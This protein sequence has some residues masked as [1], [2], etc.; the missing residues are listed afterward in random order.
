MIGILDL[1]ICNL[2]SIYNAI[3]NLGYEVKIIN[4]KNFGDVKLVSK[5]ILPG[6]GS[7][8]QISKIYFNHPELVNEV[9]NYFKKG[10]YFLG[11]C[12]GMQFLSSEGYENGLSKGL[13]FIPGVVK[14]FENNSNLKIP[15]VGW[16]EINILKKDQNIFFDILNNTNFYFV[17]SYYFNLDN[18]DFVL[19]ETNYGINFPAVVRKENTFGF[20]F[21]PE[22][23]SKKGLMLLNNFCAI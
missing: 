14:K 7:Y 6:V 4:E 13:G 20:Q 22:K 5:I 17:H 12:L 10:N 19:A 11:I 3:Y 16:N 1:G 2:K 21:H 9:N 18:Y 15:H 8:S 23:S